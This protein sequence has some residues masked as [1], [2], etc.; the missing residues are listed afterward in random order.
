[1]IEYVENWWQ[2][3]EIGHDVNEKADG[4]RQA[5]LMFLNSAVTDCPPVAQAVL[6]LMTA[7][8]A[9]HLIANYVV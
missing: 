7:D 6:E 9:A 3:Y 8:R 2:L 1:M 4:N 5:M